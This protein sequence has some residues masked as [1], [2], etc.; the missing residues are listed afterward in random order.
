M[1]NAHAWPLQTAS[2]FLSSRPVQVTRAHFCALRQRHAI[3]QLNFLCS[4]CS[5]HFILW[6]GFSFSHINCIL[7]RRRR[8]SS[9][10]SF[11][12]ISISQERERINESWIWRMPI[13][14]WPRLGINRTTEVRETRPETKN[15]ICTSQ[16]DDTRLH[17]AN[18]MQPIYDVRA[19]LQL[20]GQVDYNYVFVFLSLGVWRRQYVAFES[21]GV[22]R[23]RFDLFSF[24]FIESWRAAGMESMKKQK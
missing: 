9:S 15:I 16:W 22:V 14:K 12:P 18:A 24:R 20:D 19:Y 11:V 8:S 6:I 3:Y 2:H 5:A 17:R 21:S 10:S 23:R 1:R 7:G 13:Q 4:R